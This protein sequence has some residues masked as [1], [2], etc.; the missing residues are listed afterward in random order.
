MTAQVSLANCKED[1]KKVIDAADK[2]IGEQQKTID[3]Y[4][5]Q[6]F[7]QTKEITRLNI[8]LNEKNQELSSLV[9]NPYFMIGL[10][11][12]VGGALTLTLTR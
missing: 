12:L 7:L 8:D 4:K 11:V 2:V 9:R 5:D 10:G 6:V 3:L 1:C